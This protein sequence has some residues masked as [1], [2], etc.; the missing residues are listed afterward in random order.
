[1]GLDPS[2]T[3]S[4]IE[5][6]VIDGHKFEQSLHTW[7]AIGKDGKPIGGLERDGSSKSLALSVSGLSVSSAGDGSSE[8]DFEAGWPGGSGGGSTCTECAA[9][10]PPSRVPVRPPLRSSA[11]ARGPP[12]LSTIKS[13]SKAEAASAESDTGSESPLPVARR[14]DS[15]NSDDTVAEPDMANRPIGFRI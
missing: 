8:T 3:T 15:A 7:E 6:L 12:A 2:E 11:E 5:R 9:A 14:E 4:M 10:S 13:E 1:M